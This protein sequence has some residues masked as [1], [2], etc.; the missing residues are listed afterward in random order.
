V[1]TAL[2]AE[3]ETPCLVVDDAGL[4]ANLR[5][6]ATSAAERGLALRPHAKTHKCIEIARRQLALGAVG[7]TVATIGEAEV[8]AAA[9]CIDLFIGYPVWAIGAKAQRLRA[10]AE[11]CTLSVGVDSAEGAE[12][13]GR[14]LIGTRSRCLVEIDSGHHRSGV[15][16]ADVVTIAA[17]AA[18][19]GLPVAGV[20]T[21]P[22]HGYEPH[23][24]AAA[25]D[26]EG[27]A[28]ATAAEAL[29]VAGFD[30]TVRS[31]GSTP[32]AALTSSTITEIRPGV[33]VF[34]DAQQ[35]ELGT[36]DWPSIALTAAA[37]VVS[38][39]GNTIIVDAGS[40]TLGA[41]RAPW[42]T[43]WGRL[44]ELP[45]ARI[46]ALSEH[47]ATIAIPA[48]ESV[49]ELGAVVRVVPNHVCAAVNLADELI[50]VRYDDGTGGAAIVDRWSV[51][52]RGKNS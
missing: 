12:L 51:A 23:R 50:V 43:G 42:A 38:R 6:T 46:V 37:T 14:A 45:E 16:P 27:R 40:K 13:V 32:T 41:D 17:G 26:D 24:Q 39:T 22:G 11:L 44:L 18:R 29:H 28:L 47:H 31:G 3:L 9:G 19:A 2:P 33:Y 52:A 20:F 35:V 36:A 21:F 1:V 7:L 5:A 10:L 25:A 8:F 15:R 34:N 4:E 30:A 49:P 48:D